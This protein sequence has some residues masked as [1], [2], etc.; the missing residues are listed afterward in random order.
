MFAPAPSLMI[1][2]TATPAPRCR[3]EVTCGA[4]CWHGRQPDINRSDILGSPR[5]LASRNDTVLRFLA[6]S[7]AGIDAAFELVG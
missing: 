6:Q 5:I 1:L 3:R 2:L 7:L 4:V